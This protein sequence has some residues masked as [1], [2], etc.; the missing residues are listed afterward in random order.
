MITVGDFT[1]T[2]RMDLSFWNVDDYRRNWS[3][4]LLKLEEEEISTAC[5]ISSIT[6]PDNSNFVFCWPLYRS[7]EEVFVQN[8]VIFLGELDATFDAEKP[9]SFVEQR[10]VVDDDGNQISEWSTKISHVRQFRESGICG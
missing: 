4:A 8:S 10:Q 6:D 9:W 7:G 2:F 5:L 3:R 1:E